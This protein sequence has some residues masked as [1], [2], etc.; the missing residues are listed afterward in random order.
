MSSANSILRAS[1][2]KIDELFGWHF[3]H[4]QDSTMGVAP[5]ASPILDQSVK[6]RV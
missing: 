5:T 2:E 4:N 1:A 3:L 6:M